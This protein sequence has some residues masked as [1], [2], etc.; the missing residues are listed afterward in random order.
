MV[1]LHVNYITYINPEQLERPE[2]ILNIVA[3]DALEVKQQAIS[4]HMVVLIKY[5]LYWTSFILK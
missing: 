1:F 2:Y 3:T 4:I 5:S